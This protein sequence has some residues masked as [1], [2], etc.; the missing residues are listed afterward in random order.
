MFLINKS[1]FNEKDVQVIETHANSINIF[2]FIIFLFNFQT[3]GGIIQ[4]SKTYKS[5]IVPNVIISALF[6]LVNL[7]SFFLYV[8]C[9]CFTHRDSFLEIWTSS[10][11]E[12]LM[13]IPLIISIIICQTTVSNYLRIVT[14]V[15]KDCIS[16]LFPSS[17]NYTKD[18]YF[19]FL[20]V[21]VIYSIP[22]STTKSLSFFIILSF[23]EFVFV[24]LLLSYIIYSFCD[25]VSTFGFDPNN[26]LLIFKFDK[27]II[28]N[29]A[30]FMT[31][32]VAL[33]L[34]FPS[35]GHLS[36]PTQNRLMR[37]FIIAVFLSYVFYNLYGIFTYLE[38]FN[39]L[40]ENV[41]LS[42]YDSINFYAQICLI[43]II[44]STLPCYLNQLRF[45]VIQLYSR[46]ESMHVEIWMMTGII[47]FMLG[48][49]ISGFSERY[50]KVINFIREISC[51]ILIYVLVPL[52][53]IR[54]FKK[55]NKLHLCGSLLL[56]LIGL[57]SIVISVIT[58][59]FHR[60]VE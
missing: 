37:S 1:R 34:N 25:S 19:I 4:M 6:M 8:K 55:R 42:K 12:K 49:L 59:F 48:F 58:N 53:Y 2:E 24:I 43:L 29:I 38:F 20:F 54:A 50:F 21:F 39:N 16:F 11:S 60:I 41:L 32:Y 18:H 9:A 35:L 5:G 28:E 36:C 33:P 22:I 56:F 7:Y 17:P 27:K 15:I 26:D 52:M 46:N 23:L 3:G 40:P 47:I 51:E 13:A 57:C 10:V 31:S 44:L 30:I 14:L 45:L